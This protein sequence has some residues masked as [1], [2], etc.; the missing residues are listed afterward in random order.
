MKYVSLIARGGGVKAFAD[1]FIFYVNHSNY[2]AFRWEVDPLVVKVAAVFHASIPRDVIE[3]SV[4]R[5]GFCIQCFT[6]NYF[7][8]SVRE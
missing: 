6:I 8:Q 5:L 3:T 7:F 1:A 2:Y 4:A